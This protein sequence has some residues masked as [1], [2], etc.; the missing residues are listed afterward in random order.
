MVSTSK[1]AIVKT[2]ALMG[3]DSHGWKYFMICLWYESKMWSM[4]SYAYTQRNKS[5][6]GYACDMN[7]TQTM[8]IKGIYIEEHILY[9]CLQNGYC[10]KSL[11]SNF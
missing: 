11:C 7:I 4:P 10:L 3:I 2:R 5:N 8:H 1:L 9:R 6:L